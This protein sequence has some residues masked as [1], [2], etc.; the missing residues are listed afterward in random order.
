MYLSWYQQSAEQ[1]ELLRSEYLLLQLECR[2]LKE[3]DSARNLA[4]DWDLQ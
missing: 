3:K 4:L 2:L 1:L